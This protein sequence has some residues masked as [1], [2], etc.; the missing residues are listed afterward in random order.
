MKGFY[1]TLKQSILFSVQYFEDLAVRFVRN[2]STMK[3]ER[4]I[5]GNFFFFSKAF[6]FPFDREKNQQCINFFFFFFC[7]SKKPKSIFNKKTSIGISANTSF[8]RIDLPVT[9]LRKRLEKELD[10]DL[11]VS[12]ICYVGPKNI[13]TKW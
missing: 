6:T 1:L 10:L 13:L 8:E 3:F 7:R 2:L 12:S 5:L 11:R 9:W 4:V